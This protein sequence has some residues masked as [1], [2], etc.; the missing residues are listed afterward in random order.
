MVS[1]K[2]LSAAIAG[3]LF[4]AVPAFAAIDST[5]NPVTGKVK[6][7]KE[8]ITAAA[9]DGYYTFT[10]AANA[11]G[12]VAD[13]GVGVDGAPTPVKRYVRV[14]LGNA[15]FVTA[16]TAA[17]AANS[18][19]A[20]A[21]GGAGKNFVIFE[22]TFAA[23]FVETDNITISVPDLA[24]AS[25]FA[26]VSYTYTIYEN[27]TNAV[28]KTGALNNEGKGVSVTDAASVVSGIK[29]SLSP[30]TSTAS[31]DNAFKK[32]VGTPAKTVATIG[33]FDVTF[34]AGVTAAG[35]AAVTLL[36]QVFDVAASAS[37]VT[38]K[39]DFSTGTW[40]F[41]SASAC[42]GSGTTVGLTLNTAKTEATADFN[43]L[44]DG[45]PAAATA[46]TV[47]YLC[48]S[49]VGA[50]V[51]PEGNY[52]FT[53]D[54]KG[55]ASTKFEPADLTGVIGTIDRDGT[56]V[57]VPYVST[58]DEYNQRLVLVNRGSADVA[59]T[60]TFTPET[61]VTVAP[62]TKATGTLKA[63]STTILSAK[64]VVTITGATRTAATVTIVSSTGNI[65]A[66]TTMV[67][68]ADKSTDTVKLK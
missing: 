15:K 46:A 67:N 32:F 66:A 43:D 18:T 3:A 35:G 11:L 34:E 61:G 44:D 26:P 60:V 2:L 41:Q 30:L 58:F 28:N 50:D 53:L 33:S 17:M 13:V 31:V 56:V 7:A 6:F 14:D 10:G 40:N 62:G 12:L 39:G 52:N 38:V 8:S 59:Y 1:K 21:Q 65:D 29:A 5:A 20:I 54:Y 48:V 64:D 47:K 49:G 63:K 25:S 9:V 68:L 45:L 36:N 4:S 22:V 16:P 27:L 51:I 23:D 24:I 37:K 57:Q 42:D 19:D 55:I